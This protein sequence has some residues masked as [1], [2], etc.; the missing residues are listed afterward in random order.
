MID[1]TSTKRAEETYTSFKSGDYAGATFQLRRLAEENDYTACRALGT[2]YETGRPGV[3][4]NYEEALKW[5]KRAIEGNSDPVATFFYARM[6]YFGLGIQKDYSNALTYL[7]KIEK[8]QQPSVYYLIALIYLK[9]KSLRDLKSAEKYLTKA[10]H[11][12]HLEA[13]ATLARLLI[14]TGRIKAG[15]Y[16]LWDALKQF[17]KLSSKKDWRIQLLWNYENKDPDEV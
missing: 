8:E 10:E 14:R 1:S 12:G 4:Q 7:K 6:Y 17:R 15:L 3:A 5:Y 2:I 16:K 9:S 11:M 13:K